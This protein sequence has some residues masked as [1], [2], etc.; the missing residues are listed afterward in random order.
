MVLT[1][2]YDVGVVYFQIWKHL[3]RMQGPYLNI[4]NRQKIRKKRRKNMNSIHHCYDDEGAVS[5]VQGL[6]LK[7]EQ[8]QKIRMIFVVA[9][10][11]KGVYS[12]SISKYR[13]RK[14]YSNKMDE[15]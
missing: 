4:E 14:K 6:H 9:I 5:R 12:G 15:K 10:M 2:N 3:F 7:M 11:L 13:N 8:S 1:V